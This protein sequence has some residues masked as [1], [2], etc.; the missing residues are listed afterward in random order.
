MVK[1]GHLVLLTGRNKDIVFRSSG[2]GQIRINGNDLL[3]SKIQS[4]NQGLDDTITS[5]EIVSQQNSP[6]NQFIDRKLSIVETRINSR[7]DELTQRLNDTILLQ[8]KIFG[9]KQFR[10]IRTMLRRLDRLEKLLTKNE[11]DN[12]P[13]QNG[14]TCEDGFNQYFCRCRSGFMGQNCEQD[15]DECVQY[16]GTELGCQ[17]GGTCLNIFG[18]FVCLCPANHQ[19]LRCN[20]EFNDCHNVSDHEIC[21]QGLCL[22][23]PRTQNKVAAFRC[24]CFQGFTKSNPNIESAPC[25]VDVD[26]CRLGIDRCSKDPPVDCIN[27]R[28][29]YQCGP[30]PSGYTGDGFHCNAYDRC[31]INNGGCSISPRV[32]CFP[33]SSSDRVVCGPCPPGYVGDGIT[34]STV[35]GDICSTNNGGCSPDA[36]CIANVAI[37]ARFRQCRCNDGYTG[38]GEGSQGCQRISSS[39]TNCINNPCQHGATCMSYIH[40]GVSD[41]YCIC[42]P[43]YTGRYCENQAN[44]CRTNPCQNGGRC[45]NNHGVH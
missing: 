32:S 25:D 29:G 23:I 26:E 18:S 34:C 31:L 39:A 36:T 37:S 19:G 16:Q 24:V 8:K 38:S 13:C 45:I 1:N 6:I 14:A 42:P 2:S 27:T 28:D 17:N 41:V 10:R 3:A 33:S 5:N 9:R 43:D 30:C 4:I 7:I 15:V 21:G 35:D 12:N 40:H 22:N 44:L 11:C 20:I